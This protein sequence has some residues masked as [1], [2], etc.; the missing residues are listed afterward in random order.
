MYTHHFSAP[1]I[2]AMSDTQCDHNSFSHRAFP[3][4]VQR[5]GAAVIEELEAS[6]QSAAAF[7]A[8]A[9][10]VTNETFP[11][12]PT[13]SLLYL[14]DIAITADEI[15]S[16]PFAIVSLT[17]PQSHIES[18][19]IGLLLSGQNPNLSTSRIRYFTL[20]DAGEGATVLCEWSLPL[21]VTAGIRHLNHGAGST[22]TP[23]AF[24]LRVSQFLRSES[25]S[26][27][28]FPQK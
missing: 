15:D 17:K 26:S 21:D 10:D 25:D 4:I 14:R 13:R 23:A 11:Q 18:Y 27:D 1:L 28:S 7:L 20:E 3:R 5:N 24:Q 16:Q 9:F 6:P 22:P 12:S 8:W 19:C 2:P